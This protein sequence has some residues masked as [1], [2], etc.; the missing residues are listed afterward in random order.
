MKC[1]E[2]APTGQR[3]YA[4]QWNPNAPMPGWVNEIR[5]HMDQVREGWNE[6]RRQYEILP[7]VYLVEERQK[8]GP[9]SFKPVSLTI[10]N[11]VTA[12]FVRQGGWAV[13]HPGLRKACELTDEEF[14]CLYLCEKEPD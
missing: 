14:R 11:S 10:G 8:D 4:L 1:P 2:Y 9:Q 13:Y 6:Y 3:V 7:G 5:A 12:P